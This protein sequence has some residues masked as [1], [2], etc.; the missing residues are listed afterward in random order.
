M[1]PSGPHRGR[2]HSQARTCRLMQYIEYFQHCIGTISNF[3]SYKYHAPIDL[4]I[5]YKELRLTK[6][7]GSDVASLAESA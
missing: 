5:A 6:C 7:S 2:L 3:Y 1:G 4:Y